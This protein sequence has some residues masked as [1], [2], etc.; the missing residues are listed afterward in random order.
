MGVVRAELKTV[1]EAQQA[2][3][4]LT[5]YFELPKAELTYRGI[6]ISPQRILCKVMEGE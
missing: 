6:H 3:P 2:D 4:V 1:Q 5:K